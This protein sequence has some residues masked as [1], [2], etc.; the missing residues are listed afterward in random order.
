MNLFPNWCKSSEMSYFCCWQLAAVLCLVLW[1]SPSILPGR[2]GGTRVGSRGDLLDLP[3]VCCVSCV[4]SPW[5][6]LAPSMLRL[7]QLLPHGVPWT[8]SAQ[9]LPTPSRPPLGKFCS[10]LLAYLYW[11]LVFPHFQNTWVFHTLLFSSC[12]LL[13]IHFLSISL[14]SC[15]LSA[16]LLVFC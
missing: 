16:A 10:W 1:R 3:Q 6:W 11:G 13:V 5:G 14:I 8:V 12:I 4:W 7:S 15:L 2:W 9:H